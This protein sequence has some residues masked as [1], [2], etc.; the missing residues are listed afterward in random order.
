MRVRKGDLLIFWYAKNN[1]QG[2]AVPTC[3]RSTH[4]HVKEEREVDGNKKVVGVGR[5]EGIWVSECNALYMN[6]SMLCTWIKLSKTCGPE[7]SKKTEV[8]TTIPI[9]FITQIWVLKNICLSMLS[10]GNPGIRYSFLHCPVKC[11]C[12]E[13]C[14]NQCIIF[15]M[16]WLVKSQ[17][18]SLIASGVTISNTKRT[19]YTH[20]CYFWSHTHNSWLFRKPKV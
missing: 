18:H 5:R 9:K 4:K 15:F 6:H 19:K 1:E 13:V 20:S 8:S 3:T 10:N 12:F 2:S 17:R 14:L 11:V 7:I 16:W